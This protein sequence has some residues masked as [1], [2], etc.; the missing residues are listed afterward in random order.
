MVVCIHNL[1]LLGKWTARPTFVVF[2]LNC[3]DLP[4]GE[5]VLV[6][7]SLTDNLDKIDQ[8]V[9]PLIEKSGYTLYDLEFHGRTLRVSIE[10]EG[11]VTIEDCV[12]TSRLL[13]P[14]LDVEDVIPGGRYELEV[15]SPGLD[16]DLK[17]PQH[18]KSVLGKTIYVQTQEPMSKWNQDE[19]DGVE[20]LK[21]FEKRKKI[22]G[23]LKNLTEENIE[24]MAEGRNVLIPLKAIHRAY[25]D[26]ELAKGQKKT[27]AKGPGAKR[28]GKV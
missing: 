10:K 5:F 28:K 4:F 6:F 17:K 22:K 21:F 14:V 18:F 15:S 23:E 2:S 11:G 16:R 1:S 3:L 8:I 27:F 9:R 13:N 24:L 26:F 20:V 25:L 19:Q 12:E 7:E